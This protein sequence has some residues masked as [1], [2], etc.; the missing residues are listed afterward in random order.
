MRIIKTVINVVSLAF[1]S[2]V[3]MQ[4]GAQVV[5]NPG[6]DSWKDSYS[7]GN[8]CYC[9]SSYDHG[10]GNYTVSTPAGTKTVREVC[11]ALGPGPGSDGYPIYNTVQCGHDPAHNDTIN[12][13]GVQVADEIECPGRVDMGPSGCDVIGPK[14]DLEGAF[15]TSQPTGEYVSMRKSNAMSYAIDGNNGGANAQNVYL[16]SFNSSNQNQHWEEISRGGDYYS[17]KKR[18]TNYCLDGDHGGAN[19]QNVYL[20]TCSTNNQNQHW[21]KVYVSGQYR[22]EKRNASGYSLDGNR[23][24]ANGQNL[25]L[26]QSNNAN[27]NQLWEFGTH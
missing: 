8:T 17:Y 13:G 25:Y 27:P 9:D 22:L 15:G 19:G 23:G 7:V 4:A 2:S 1:A 12:I 5:I 26:W 21:K 11:E 3:A 6:G 10:I 20:W 16:W 24:G 14:W 18:G